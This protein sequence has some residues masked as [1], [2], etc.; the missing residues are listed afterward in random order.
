MGDVDIG[1]FN[2]GFEELLEVYR[3]DSMG[4]EPLD[5][6]YYEKMKKLYNHE[7]AKLKL[8]PKSLISG[9]DIMKILDIEPG[10]K[11][12]KILKEIREE[13]LDGKINN[14]KEAINYI[15]NLKTFF[16]D[17]KYLKYSTFTRTIL[18]TPIIKRIRFSIQPIRGILDN[19]K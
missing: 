12:G 14:K 9:K 8:M 15:K 11:V 3:A 10:E 5:L 1:F 13:Q 6:E 17:F 2:L 18:P 7:I 16:L 4:I 19:M